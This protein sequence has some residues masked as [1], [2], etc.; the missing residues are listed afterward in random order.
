MKPTLVILKTLPVITFLL[1]CCSISAKAQQTKQIACWIEKDTQSEE[2][3]NFKSY[4]RNDSKA[5]IEDLSYEF[6][7]LK[8]SK[9]GKSNIKQAGKFS[10][11][12]GQEITLS[13]IQLN[14]GQSRSKVFK[15][16]LKIF[17]RDSLINTDSLIIAP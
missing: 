7:S 12:P 16:Q 13:T 2:A 1:A 6:T 14:S 10:A 17:H 15:L 3:T 11:K 4:F 8:E 9:S 5:T